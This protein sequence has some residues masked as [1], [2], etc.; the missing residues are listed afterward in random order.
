MKRAF[1]LSLLAVACVPKSDIGQVCAVAA[2]C[3][4]GLECAAAKCTYPIG[5]RVQASGVCGDGVI[6]SSE[7]CDKG[8]PDGAGK[9][10]TQET[11]DDGD[12]CTIDITEPDTC[13]AECVKTKI[14]GNKHGD[15]CCQN[16]ATIRASMDD[17][18]PK[19]GMFETCKENADCA[20]NICSNGNGAYY[21]TQCLQ[22]CNEAE[23]LPE[24]DCPMAIYKTK[25][26]ITKSV[27]CV[28]DNCVALSS[29]DE[30]AKWIVL[31]EGVKASAA[32]SQKTYFFFANPGT[33]STTF[34]ATV[35]PTGSGGYTS[36]CNGYDDPGYRC[37]SYAPYE[38]TENLG[39]GKRMVWQVQSDMPYE[40][41][42]TKR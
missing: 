7:T 17:D 5:A 10:P 35:T 28:H 42:V 30:K 14:L 41:V 9:C 11:C 3:V 15:G 22:T 26:G 40:V 6:N 29:F 32:A 34:T 20:S 25:D 19:L 2:D 38:G 21:G 31:K 8:I 37:D 18:C 12:G 13:R 23:P 36:I 1:V 4:P 16:P 33:K 24:G 27:L 39:G